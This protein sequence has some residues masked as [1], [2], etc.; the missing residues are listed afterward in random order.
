MS[1][2]FSKYEDVI[3]A[4]AL[5]VQIPNMDWEDV[6]QELRIHLW[7]KSNVFNPKYASAATFVNNILNNK[8]RDLMKAAYRKKRFLDTSHLVFSEILREEN[9]EY[10]LESAIPIEFLGLIA[11]E[12]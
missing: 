2:N 4:K 11:Y 5:K 9:G 6:A 10:L 1:I 8:I 7:L 12:G 3:V